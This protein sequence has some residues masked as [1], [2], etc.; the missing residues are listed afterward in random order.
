MKTLFERQF[1]F[2][3]SSD[4]I[5]PW[6]GDVC[7]SILLRI[8]RN[9]MYKGIVLDKVQ[10]NTFLSMAAQEGLNGL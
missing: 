8:G 6:A 4:K 2:E 7:G 5:E 3:E 9:D 10:T 1:Q